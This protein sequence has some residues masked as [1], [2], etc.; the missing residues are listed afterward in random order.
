MKSA[1]ANH[2]EAWYGDGA[3]VGALARA[4]LAAYYANAGRLDEAQKLA[5]EVSTRFPGAVD[6]AGSRLTD[7]LRKMKLLRGP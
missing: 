5:E 7:V 1:I 3:Q 2:G 4:Q 6:H